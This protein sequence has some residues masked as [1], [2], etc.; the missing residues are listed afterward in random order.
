MING[1]QKLSIVISVYNEKDSVL[2]LLEKISLIEIL[3]EKEIIIIDDG[4]T[5]GT[6]NI[7]KNLDSSKYKV[8]LKEKNEGK[9][10]TIKEGF[11]RATGDIIIVQDADLEYNPEDYNI[12]LKPILDGGVDV[13]YGSRMLDQE[14]KR[15]FY[16]QSYFANKF[17]TKLSNIFTG[18]HLTDMETC[19][20]V[21]SREVLDSFK[22]ELRSKRFGIEPEITAKI[23]K[24]KWRLREVP[25]SYNGR[26]YTKGK[27]VGWKDGL[28][29]VW[30]IIRF[31]LFI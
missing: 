19:Y 28:A 27:K 14:N 2:V 17:L 1:K 29:T 23:A 5:D 21:F 9:G 3:L 15:N 30:H 8:F 31:N 26:S 24:G 18:L 13:V 16:L 11:L 12:L 22:N 6:E 7:L 20:K 10:A 4:S 25:I